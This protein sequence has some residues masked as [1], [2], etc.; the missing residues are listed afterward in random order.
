M[1]R[2]NTLKIFLVNEDLFCLTMYQQLLK[3]M[4][5]HDIHAFSSGEECLKEIGQ[6]PN[7]VLLHYTLQLQA[8]IEVLKSIKGT[9]PG[10]YVV[11]ISGNQ[12]KPVIDDVLKQGAYDHIISGPDDAVKI[13]AALVKI[14]QIQ[15]ILSTK[16]LNYNKN[17]DTNNQ[18]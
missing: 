7:I 8:G 16:P 4:G 6:M 10:I 14:Q 3:N 9:F 5:Y 18:S 1:V 13:Q 11:I 15:N 2:N 12:L 17:K